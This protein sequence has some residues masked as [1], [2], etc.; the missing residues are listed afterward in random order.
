M[1]ANIE[2]NNVFSVREPMWHGLGTILSNAPSW[3]AIPDLINCNWTA[4]KVN[5][6]QKLPDG[7]KSN[8]SIVNVK[9]G[10]IVGYIRELKD[11]Y[12]IRRAKDGQ[13]YGFVK[14]TYIPYQ[15]NEL[16]DLMTAMAG[17]GAIPETGGMLDN[18]RTIFITCKAEG[19]VF[20]EENLD[21]YFVL[22]NTHGGGGAIR[23]A[24]TPIRVVCQ[25]TLNAGLRDAKRSWAY[26]HTT[27]VKS[28]VDEAVQ[29]L[30]NGKAYMEALGTEIS[31]M[32]LTK[33]TEERA[34]QVLDQIVIKEN[35]SKLAKIEVLK[36]QTPFDYNERLKNL[37]KIANL[38]KDVI[39]VQNDLYTR[40]FDAPDLQDMGHNQ[41]R[42]WN[43][44]SDYATHTDLHK[45]TKQYNEKLFMAAVNDNAIGKAKL[46][47]FG[48]KLAKAA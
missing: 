15:N 42:L 7:I 46:I 27:N 17:L 34:K 12:E 1:A 22:T 23:A 39:D 38:R 20:A 13:H 48:Y 28:H 32:K 4:E 36:K 35:E 21:Q 11:D 43:A 44:I 3:D 40:Y 14:E 45:K 5:A 26:K 33:I 19:T 8:L 29:T 2:G 6:I 41:F 24:I 16:I 47:D 37:E 18:G 25:N 9:T 31:A 30:M 10:E